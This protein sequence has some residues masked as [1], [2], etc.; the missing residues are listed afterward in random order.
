MSFWKNLFGG[1]NSSGGERVLASESYK[2]FTI[3]AI[4][5]K[6]GSEYQLCGEIRLQ[7]GDEEKVHRFIRADRLSSADQAA[8]FTLRKAQQIIDQQGRTIFD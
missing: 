4:E 3:H 5:M 6:A 7:G 1:G 8:E 2:E